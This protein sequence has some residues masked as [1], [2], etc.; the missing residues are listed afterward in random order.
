MIS[1]VTG[2]LVSFSTLIQEPTRHLTVGVTTGM[3]ALFLDRCL[4]RTLGVRLR[5]WIE[6]G[7]PIRTNH[8]HREILKERD[9]C[10]LCGT[11][12]TGYVRCNMCGE[13][14]CGP[15]HFDTFHSNRSKELSDLFESLEDAKEQKKT[16][17]TGGST[18]LSSAA[19]TTTTTTATTV[20]A[21]L[22]GSGN[23]Q[24]VGSS[25]ANTTNAPAAATPMDPPDFDRRS[26]GE[27]D[28]DESPRSTKGG[29]ASKVR[30]QQTMQKSD[31]TTQ[32]PSAAPSLEHSKKRIRQSRPS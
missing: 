16:R 1:L 2:L 27:S 11:R 24:G 18:K 10:L 7:Y 8:I 30:D 26:I 20:T 4:N 22:I 31:Q 15:D 29:K 19:T 5:W 6:S 32:R 9:I 28:E 13:T 12:G 25:I 14:F 21:A 23:E 3:A 17:S